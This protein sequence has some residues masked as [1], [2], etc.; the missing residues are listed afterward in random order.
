MDVS[1]NKCEFF[2]NIVHLSTAVLALAL[3]ANYICK[4]MCDI[5]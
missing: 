3:R 5:I 2:G 4:S 1:Q